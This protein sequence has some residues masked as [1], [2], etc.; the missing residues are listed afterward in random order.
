MRLFNGAH[1]FGNSNGSGIHSFSVS[2]D[3]KKAYFALLTRGFGITDVSAFTDTD[4][5]TNTYRLITPAANRVS[6]PGPG[7]HSAVKLWNKDWVYVSDEVYGKITGTGHGC[8][9]GWARFVDVADET[10]PVVRSEFRLPENQPLACTAFDP[11]RTSYSA[12][13]P[14][15]TPSIAFST[16]HSGG[17]QAIDI[18]NPASPTQLA[19]FKP[20]AAAAR[21]RR[22]PA[23]LL[24]RTTLAG[25]H[26][27]QGRDVELPG[28]PGRPDLHGRP[29]QR[30]L[31]PQVQRP[32][33]SRRSTTSGSWRATPTRATRSASSR[34]PGQ[35]PPTARRRPTRRAARAARCRPRSSLTL[36]AAGELRHVHARRGEGLH[37]DHDRQRHLL[38]G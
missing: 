18:T 27:Q 6:W 17:F 37:G 28:D 3:G 8:P 31:H 19:E 11:P 38:R 24:R 25:P 16:W 21:R 12:H 22:G 36:G 35:V 9:W 23:A 10:R 2:N 29:A 4:P 13:N 15:L 30:P 32:V 7:A 34:C 1:G 20:D 14:T 26:R 5:A 33:L